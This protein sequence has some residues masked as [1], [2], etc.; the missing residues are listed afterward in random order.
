MKIALLGYGKMGKMIEEII[1][2]ENK[3]E[4]VLKISSSNKNLLTK[5]KLQAA[6]VAIEFSNPTSV[7]KNIKICFD[8]GIPVVVGSTGWYDQFSEV[9]DWCNK[10]NGTIVYASNFSIGVNIFFELNKKLASLMNG[11]NDYEPVI[12]EIHHTNKKDSPSGTAITLAN[13]LLSVLQLKN[14]WVNHQSSLKNELIILS[15]RIDDIVGTHIVTYNSSV[16]KIEIKHEASNRAGFAQGALM[17]A[18]WIK[19]K[20]GCY[21]F[22]DILFDQK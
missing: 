16:D 15:Q 12:E 6:D 19:S 13:D 20:K 7:L 8:A 18:E 1:L 21:E 4:V 3:D 22:R 11:R 2:R 9:K 14:H 10:A 5:E 17:A